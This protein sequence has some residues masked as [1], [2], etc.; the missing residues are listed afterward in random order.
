MDAVDIPNF[1][2]YIYRKY[3]V[4]EPTK[5]KFFLYKALYFLFITAVAALSVCLSLSHALSTP[6]KGPLL[7]S[8]HISL[9]RAYTSP[10]RNK[11]MYAD[12]GLFF[13]YYH[14]LPQEAQL[15]EEFSCSQRPNASMMV[16]LP[17]LFF[18]FL[19]FLFLC[20]IIMFLLLFYQHF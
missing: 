5:N 14:N 7:H 9:A 4:N 17:L 15:F 8:L 1:P 2:Q 19:E 11:E 16:N 18:F 6:I 3:L 10:D 20:G 13:P 12:N